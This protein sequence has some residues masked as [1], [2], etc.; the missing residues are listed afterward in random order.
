MNLAAMSDPASG[1]QD[2]SDAVEEPS[3]GGH[4]RSR[5]HLGR[6][7]EGRK[8]GEDAGHSVPNSHGPWRKPTIRASSH[9]LETTSL[10]FH[11]LLAQ[12]SS[13]IV[14]GP[15]S[16][17]QP[18]SGGAP[19]WG[20]VAALPLT[21]GPEAKRPNSH[22]EVQR[23]GYRIQIP[24]QELLPGRLAKRRRKGPHPVDRPAGGILPSGRRH[25]PVLL[26][27]GRPYPPVLP[28]QPAIL[29]QLDGH[30]QRPSTPASGRTTPSSPRWPRPP[31]PAPSGTSARPWTCLSRPRKSKG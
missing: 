25:P 26:Q 7:V 10:R 24:V 3:T 27:P 29:A 9:G 5:P 20:S 18:P 28:Q 12:E 19:C 8:S 14:P 16:A 4:Q 31:P 1:R 23:H 2:N 6:H 22:V 17:P 30:Q 11:T 15:M 13:P 21:C